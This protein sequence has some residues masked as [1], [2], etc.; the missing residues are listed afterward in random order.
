MFAIKKYFLVRHPQT[1]SY[2]KIDR[3]KSEK[4]MSGMEYETE[5]I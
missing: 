4:E 1:K 5:R 3:L 2:N